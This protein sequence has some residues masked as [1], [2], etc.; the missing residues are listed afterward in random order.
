MK[1]TDNSILIKKSPKLITKFKSVQEFEFCEMVGSGSF[2]CVHRVIHMSSGQEFALKVIK[3][4]FLVKNQ[5]E[6]E[7]FREKLLLEHLQWTPWVIRFFGAFQDSENLYFVLEYCECGTLENL[8]NIGEKFQKELVKVIMA[9]IVAIIEDIHSRGIVHRDLKL[10]NLMV[11]VTGNL[12]LIDF[13]S[14]TVLLL[15]SVND[16]VYEKFEIINKKYKSEAK[17][18]YVGGT[19][20]KLRKQYSA[21]VSESGKGKDI[22]QDNEEE[23]RKGATKSLGSCFTNSEKKL[24]NGTERKV[25][26]VEFEIEENKNTEQAEP[27]PRP[28]FCGS[29]LYISPEMIQ[30]L[31][32]TFQCDLW[33]IGIIFFRLITGEFPF[34]SDSDFLRFQAIVKDDVRFPKD[35]SADEKNLV[36]ALLEKDPAKRP[37]NFKDGRPS[38]ES[39]KQHP[40]FKGI[41]W[42]QIAKPSQALKES[43]GRFKI[44]SERDLLMTEKSTMSS[45][46]ERKI[47][48]TGL[49]KKMK[50]KVLYNTRLLIIF[51][52]GSMEY[53]DPKTNEVKGKLQLTKDCNFIP[54][55]GMNFKVEFPHRTFEFHSLECTTKQWYKNIKIFLK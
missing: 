54:I 35:I 48:L 29:P 42:Q 5:K 50:F 34:D 27:L 14:A 10:E 31:E 36:L 17:P 9:K 6:V 19:E 43:L 53:I 23:Q 33:A 45:Q 52:D 26:E 18:S 47:M 7:V 12:K 20:S 3:K 30:G 44:Y 8:V 46:R 38:L 2:A 4:Q 32:V 40:Y 1:S 11:D 41:N 15:P 49:V 28:T 25:L 51:G 16:D 39:I 24:Y 22:K 37:S 13:G 55:N 21:S